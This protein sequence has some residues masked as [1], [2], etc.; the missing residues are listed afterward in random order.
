M[1]TTPVEFRAPS[2]LTLTLELYPYGSDS[3]ANGA[4]DS[5][6]EETN[7]KGVYQAPVTEALTGWHTAHVK[8]G[9]DIVAVYD[10]Y[11]EDDTDPH[12]CHDAP[13][14]LHDGGDG[15]ALCQ[16]NT[17]MRGTDAGALA[18]VCTEVRLA[19]LAA[20]ALPASI[21]AIPTTPMRG[22]DSAALASVCLEARLAKLDIAGVLAHSGAAGTYKA[23]VSALALEATLT[24]A[25]KLLQN[26]KEFDLDN[27]KIYLWNDAGSA[28]EYE[29]DLTDSEDAAVTASTQGPINCSRWTAV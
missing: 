5:A 29:A 20:A 12:R 9:S 4:G 13:A 7:R 3:I 16:V 2:G 8:S 17:D 22:T 15:A 23:D 26:R 10:I 21:A 18:S 6:T 24:L 19:Q 14:R 25:R 28:R 11:L 27:S 1:A